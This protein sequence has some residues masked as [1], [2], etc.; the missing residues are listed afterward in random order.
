MD[1]LQ[2]IPN[3][4]VERDK[5]GCNVVTNDLHL[6]RLYQHFLDLFKQHPHEL[7]TRVVCGFPTVDDVGL[8]LR[9]NKSD[10]PSGTQETEVVGAPPDAAFQCL[11]SPNSGVDSLRKHT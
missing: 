8:I 3:M 9:Q 11:R 7:C 1:R 6:S 10:D 5:L 2:D 4:F